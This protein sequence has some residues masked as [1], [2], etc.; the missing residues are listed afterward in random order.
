LNDNALK[1][2]RVLMITYRA[3]TANALSAGLQSV[4][5]AI[6]LG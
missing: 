2:A 5:S 3:D 6:R 4:Y 1:N